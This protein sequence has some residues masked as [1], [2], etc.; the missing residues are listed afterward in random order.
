MNG[1]DRIVIA[2]FGGSLRKASFSK[3]VLERAKSFMPDG[4]MLKI[5]DIS[6][7]P[8]FNADELGEPQQSV[9][10][11][12]DFI[13]ETDGFLIVTPEYNYSVPGFLKNAIDWASVP[14]NVFAKKTGAIM[15]SSTGMMGGARAQYHLM[16]SFVFLDARIIN[17]P[18]VIINFVDKKINEKGEF[19]DENA[20][21]FMR[22]LLNNLVTEVSYQR[23][24]RS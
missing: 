16:Q 12:R 1:N 6:K 3:K 18:E 23:Q 4:S 24:I 21:K 19:A 13:N 14:K 20:E 22:D 10:E 5:F 17:R 2:G 15:S 7:I 9:V 11:F 8:L